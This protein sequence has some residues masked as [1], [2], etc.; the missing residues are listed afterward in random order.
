MFGTPGC[1]PSILN[2]V[3]LLGLNSSAVCKQSIFKAKGIALHKEWIG[4][5]WRW[6]IQGERPWKASVW[7]FTKCTKC[8]LLIRHL[9]AGSALRICIPDRTIGVEGGGGAS[10]DYRRQ[11]NDLGLDVGVGAETGTLVLVEVQLLGRLHLQ[12]KL[13]LSPH[14]P[15]S[16]ALP[17]GVQQGDS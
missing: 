1:S 17:S 12:R 9:T 11:V 3:E 4:C 7:V 2:T 16:L 13:L 6:W 14:A 15:S 5:L 10:G 8:R